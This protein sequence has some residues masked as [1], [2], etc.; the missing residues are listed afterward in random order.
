MVAVADRLIW[1]AASALIHRFGENAAAI[2]AER[3]DNAQARDDPATSVQWYL[4][5]RAVE[6]LEMKT[7]SPGERVH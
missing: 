6:L 3:A 5:M 1:G 2:A 4:I 7:P